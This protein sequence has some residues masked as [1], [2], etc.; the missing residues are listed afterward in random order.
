MCTLQIHPLALFWWTVYVIEYQVFFLSQVVQKS[1]NWCGFF[2]VK[3]FRKER[4]S[5]L[6]QLFPWPQL[7]IVS[8]YQIPSPRIDWQGL[9]PIRSLMELQTFHWPGP[10]GAGV[11]F[12]PRRKSRPGLLKC[13][14]YKG[15]GCGKEI[16]LLPHRHLGVSCV[17]VFLPLTP[18]LQSNNIS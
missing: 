2:W 4:G 1:R 6:S 18:H 14:F 16:S 10:E 15:M 5:M 13:P 9:L 17:F 8:G 12:R 7:H 3:V 11:E